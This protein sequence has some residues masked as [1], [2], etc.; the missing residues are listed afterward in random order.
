MLL[1]QYPS[2]FA[3]AISTLRERVLQSFDRYVSL[4]AERRQ[5]TAYYTRALEAEQIQ[6][7]MSGRDRAAGFQIFHFA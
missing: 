1:Y 4:P 2:L 5:D 7:G 3:K 6:A